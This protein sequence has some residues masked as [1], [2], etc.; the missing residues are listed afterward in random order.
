MRNVFYL[1]ER[2]RWSYIQKQA[3]QDGIAV[4][5]DSALLP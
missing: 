5:I 3:K 1:P 4:K 2:A